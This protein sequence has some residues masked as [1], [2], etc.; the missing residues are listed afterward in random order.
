MKKY[1]LSARIKWALE[2]DYPLWESDE[3]NEE[4]I[5]FYIEESHCQENLLTHLA[6][7]SEDG[8]C[9]L[10]SIGEVKLIHIIVKENKEMQ[11]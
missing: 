3:V 5:Q 6:N 10:C 2:F 1:S 7:N 8:I 11:E 9:K 4:H